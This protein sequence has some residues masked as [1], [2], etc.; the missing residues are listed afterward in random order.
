MSGFDGKEWL[1]DMNPDIDWKNNTVKFRHNDN[2]VT[3]KGA[4]E[5]EMMTKC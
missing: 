5:T 2:N 1:E 4:T 3:I